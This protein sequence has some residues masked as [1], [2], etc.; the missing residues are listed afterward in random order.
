MDI[1][2]QINQMSEYIISI[3]D[4]DNEEKDHNEQNEQN[5]QN[6]QNEQNEQKQQRERVNNCLVIK[7][8]EKLKRLKY[9]D[10]V[11]KY[12]NINQMVK[13]AGKIDLQI[14]DKF[15]I[16]NPYSY[17]GF[18]N[19]IAEINI[20][21]KSKMYIKQ[22]YGYYYMIISKKDYI[23]SININKDN[24]INNIPTTLNVIF[25]VLEL[26]ERH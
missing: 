13:K 8:M 6:K 3:I 23:D 10:N 12:I 20:L 16:L 2:K 4:Y 15:Y 22:I 24:H 14:G 17:E 26:R 1:D 21:L 7:E 19:K 11:Y 5:E 18:I 25:R 9:K